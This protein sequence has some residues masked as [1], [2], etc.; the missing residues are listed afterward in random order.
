M[1]I[2][3]IAIDRE[4]FLTTTSSLHFFGRRKTFPQG[5]AQLE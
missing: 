1:L 3:A 4:C 2:T 5:V